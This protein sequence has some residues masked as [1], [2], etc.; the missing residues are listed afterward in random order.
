M[1]RKRMWVS[2]LTLATAALFSGMI[3]VITSSCQ[4]SGTPKID[5]RIVSFDVDASGS[6]I[7]FVGAGQG[8]TDLYLL[9]LSTKTVKR[10]TTSEVEER[11]PVFSPCGRYVL[12]TARREGFD[13]GWSLHLLDLSEDRSRVLV[14]ENGDYFPPGFTQNGKHILFLRSEASHSST[15]GVSGTRRRVLVAA[16]RA[17]GHIAIPKEM[18]LEFLDGHTRTS[19]VLLT[20]SVLGA[21]SGSGT[22]MLF[23]LNA[24]LSTGNGQPEQTALTQTISKKFGSEIYSPQFVKNGSQLVFIAAETDYNYEVWAIQ[25]DGS[26]LRRLT[27]MRSYM[28]CL[29]VAEQEG[30]CYFLKLE[31]NGRWMRKGIWRVSLDGKTAE[32]VVDYRLFE[33]PLAW[34]P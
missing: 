2:V 13:N 20:S 29:R 7:V 9:D 30:Y 6:R 19:G 18:P 32:Q 4:H 24:W 8:M 34:K 15:G 17:D 5:G 12:Y 21:P 14:S 26:N 23:D 3:L 27:E 11:T 28:E 1:F 31:R 22:L 33:E 25:A 10:L 16:L